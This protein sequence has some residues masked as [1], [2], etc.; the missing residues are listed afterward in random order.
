MFWVCALTTHAPSSAAVLGRKPDL[1]VKAGSARIPA[2]TEWYINT[3]SLVYSQKD[4]KKG[5]GQGRDGQLTQARA[6]PHTAFYRDIARSV[7]VVPAISAVALHCTC[8]NIK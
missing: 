8:I 7:P 3:P 4:I 2:P 6:R 1:T 5:P